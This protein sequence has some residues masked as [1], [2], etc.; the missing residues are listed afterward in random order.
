M[1]IEGA[2]DRMS[3][4]L[5]PDLD[6]C[7][8]AHQDFHTAILCASHNPVLSQLA[9]VIGAALQAGL[10]V[11]TSLTAATSA[12]WSRFIPSLAPGFWNSPASS[13]LSRDSRDLG[14]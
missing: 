7:T 13:T 4:R 10:R 14:L 9:S 11:S 3:Q 5:A 6:A 2:Y 8:E 1:A 12:L